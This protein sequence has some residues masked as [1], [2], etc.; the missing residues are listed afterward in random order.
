[1]RLASAAVLLL[2]LALGCDGGLKP[3]F[4]SAYCPTGICGT[5][6]FLGA[7]PDSTE[8]VRVVVYD[9]VP[10]NTTQLTAFAGLSD[11]LPLGADSAYYSCC[12]TPLPP[13]TYPWVL[14]VWKK[15]GA[16]DVTTAPALLREIGAYQNPADTTQFGLVGVPSGWGT[17]GINMVAD[18]GKMRSISDFFPPASVARAPRR[19]GR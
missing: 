11:A 1:M 8:W 17:G 16:L 9:S 14:V 6:H 5:I 4:T 15:L 3:E 2:P 7:V 18:Y 12:I 13:G 19:P 10:T